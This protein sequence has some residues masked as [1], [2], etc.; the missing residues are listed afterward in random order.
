M[1]LVKTFFE[2]FLRPLFVSVQL[3]LDQSGATAT[4]A[5]TIKQ[6]WRTCAKKIFHL[7]V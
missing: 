7:W 2:E 4:P 3:I 1:T 6:Y 5:K